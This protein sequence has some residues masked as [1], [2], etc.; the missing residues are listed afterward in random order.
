MDSYIQ[1]KEHQIPF[2]IDAT[3]DR[4]QLHKQNEPSSKALSSGI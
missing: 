2:D 3:V 4:S 1:Y